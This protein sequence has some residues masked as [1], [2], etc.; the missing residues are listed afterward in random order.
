MSSSETFA[1][2]KRR[3][4][5]QLSYEHDHTPSQR[6]IVELLVGKDNIKETVDRVNDEIFWCACSCPAEGHASKGC[7]I[8]WK[9]GT[10]FSNAYSKLL[11][12][13]GGKNQGCSCIMNAYWAA[14]EAQKSGDNGKDIWKCFKYSVGHNPEENSLYDWIRM[15]VDKNWP[16]SSVEDRDYRAVFKHTHKVSYKRI[17][18]MIF[19]LGELV[20]EKITSQLQNKHA[21]AIYDG[22]TRSGTHYIALYV[23]YILN[24][25]EEGERLEINLLGCS[26]MPASE[27]EEEEIERFSGVDDENDE[28]HYAAK[29]DATTMQSFINNLLLQYNQSVD[30]LLLAF[31]ADNTEVNRKM[32]KD[33]NLPHLPCHNHTVALD[34]SKLILVFI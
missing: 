1:E 32:A 27:A 19:L 13:F 14:Y 18:M 9:K 22:L 24:E 29:F 25:G 6:Q 21:V 23:S 20:E 5:D 33:A 7:T 2:A 26:P 10:G 17:C 11:T 12:C 28:S 4:V 15:I 31:V 16:V 30:S 8:K 3:R 34:V